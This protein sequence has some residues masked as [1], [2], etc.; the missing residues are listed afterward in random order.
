M[1]NI[2]EA[3]YHILVTSTLDITHVDRTCNSFTRALASFYMPVY[4]KNINF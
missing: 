4:N 3:E 1:K 2:S